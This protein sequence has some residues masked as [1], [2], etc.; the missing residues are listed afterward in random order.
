MVGIHGD[1]SSFKE[2]EHKNPTKASDSQAQETTAN[3]KNSVRAQL[4]GTGQTNTK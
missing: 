4:S 3:K 2:A 1:L